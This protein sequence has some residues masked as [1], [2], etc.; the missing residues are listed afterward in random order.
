MELRHFPFEQETMQKG[1]NELLYRLDVFRIVME[2][3]GPTVR[4][5]KKNC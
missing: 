4:L 3:N 2:P 5:I 1:G